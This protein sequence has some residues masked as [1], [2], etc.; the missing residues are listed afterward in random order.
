MENHRRIIRSGDQ[1]PADLMQCCGGCCSL[2]PENRPRSRAVVG[3][4]FAWLTLSHN[5]AA[6]CLQVPQIPQQHS[7]FGVLQPL[8]TLVFIAF[9]GAQE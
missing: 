8:D 2:M 4:R 3:C 1:P 9:C 6:E 7:R 5:L